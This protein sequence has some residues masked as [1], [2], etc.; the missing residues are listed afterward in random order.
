MPSDFHANLTYHFRDARKI[1]TTF[2][3]KDRL[4]ADD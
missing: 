2:I 3:G 4:D 1:M